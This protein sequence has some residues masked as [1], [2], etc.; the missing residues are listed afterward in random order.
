VVPKEIKN[1]REKSNAV[2]RQSDANGI[3][4]DQGASESRYSIEEIFIDND[5]KAIHAC[6]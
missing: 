5:I 3:F 1:H 4:R 2:S 6:Q